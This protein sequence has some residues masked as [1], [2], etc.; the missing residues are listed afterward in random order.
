MNIRLYTRCEK[1]NQRCPTWPR[2]CDYYDR[3]QRDGRRVW[4]HLPDT[5]GNKTMAQA[6]ALKKRQ[7]ASLVK[8]GLKAPDKPPAPM[9]SKAIAAYVEARRPHDATVATKLEPNLA[10]FLASVKDRPVDEVTP[11]IIEAWRT[12]QL[13]QK[14]K[15]RRGTISKNTIQRRYNSVKGLFRSLSDGKDAVLADN[16]CDE[17]ED[18]K[19]TAAE[20]R[21]WREDDVW[22]IDELP[23][24]YRLPLLVGYHC[25]C[26]RTEALSLTRHDLGP[27][28]DAISWIQIG[29]LKKAVL[30]RER[31]PIAGWVVKEL[32][33]QLK[34]KFQT[35]VFN[36]PPDPQAWSSLLTRKLRALGKQ[37]GVNTR[38]LCMH[39]TRHT[40]ATVMQDAPGVSAETAK[41]M[42]GWTTLRM[43]ETYSHPQDASKQ[44]AAEALAQHYAAARKARR[45]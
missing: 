40:A 38:G 4:V 7:D 1:K 20:R 36:P 14:S 12:A 43:V 41:Q 42:G 34:T 3:V 18:W 45:A 15:K 21:P 11:A 19:E 44:R 37:H 30:V 23:P 31:I 25:G 26:R 24:L 9:L 27:T 28:N 2:C 10:S 33:A 39:G 17:L 16:P 32:A 5:A 8:A 6:L 22:L 29:R 35:R 13:S